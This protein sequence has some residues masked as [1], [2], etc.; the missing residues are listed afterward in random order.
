MNAIWLRA[1]RKPDKLK[2]IWPRACRKQA[3]MKASGSKAFRE[4][5]RMQA[6]WPRDSRTPARMK[7]CWPRASRQ[8][9]IP[10][11]TWPRAFPDRGALSRKHNLRGPVVP[12]AGARSLSTFVDGVVD[13]VEEEKRIPELQAGH[14]FQLSIGRQ[15]NY[16]HQQTSLQASKPPSHTW[17]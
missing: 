14:A 11:A 7:I 1:S 6:V 10:K 17:P 12:V 16:K 5:A 13:H 8:P 4:P 15:Q 9:A 3:R 2:A